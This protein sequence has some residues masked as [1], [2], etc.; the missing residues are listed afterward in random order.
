[1][2]AVAEKYKNKPFP[3]FSSVIPMIPHMIFEKI[4]KD[5]IEKIYLFGSYAYGEPNEN[6]DV[7]V[8]VIIKNEINRP[9]MQLKIKTILH[10]NKI[11]PSDILVYNSNIFYDAL[12][13]KNIERVIANK[14]KILYG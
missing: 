2:T 6:S 14:G 3:D 9:E 13:L 5:T 4:D 1:M 11:V 8:C 7:D 12:K 10:D